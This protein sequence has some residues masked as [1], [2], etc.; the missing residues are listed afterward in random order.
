MQCG[1][2]A[3]PSCEVALLLARRLLWTAVASPPLGSEQGTSVVSVVRCLLVRTN[4]LWRT[5]KAG[6]EKSIEVRNIRKTS[7]QCD[8]A[9]NSRSSVTCAVKDVPD[10]FSNRCRYRVEIR[11]VCATLDG[12]SSGSEKCEAMWS[13]ERALLRPHS[14]YFHQRT[15]GEL[16]RAP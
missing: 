5:T 2:C 9:N 8:V 3:L 12:L 16:L 15:G 4:A 10:V 14:S 7:P 13:R 1:S 11:M 6:T